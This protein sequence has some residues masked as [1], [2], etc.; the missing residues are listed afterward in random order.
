M[1][2]DLDKQGNTNLRKKE[3][4]KPRS[5]SLPGLAQPITPLWR[6]L[7]LMG[8]ASTECYNYSRNLF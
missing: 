3:K 4:R 7:R 5:I 2:S 6:S 1:S 8:I